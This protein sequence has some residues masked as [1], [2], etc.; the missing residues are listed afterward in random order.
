MTK[1]ISITDRSMFGLLKNGTTVLYVCRNTTKR[2][3]YMWRRIGCGQNI[4]AGLETKRI[5]DRFYTVILC[6]F[7]AF[8]R[9]V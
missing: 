1:K 5:N 2:C 9:R 6:F 8:S 3:S 7:S 4:P